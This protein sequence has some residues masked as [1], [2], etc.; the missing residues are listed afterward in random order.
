MLL[1]EVSALLGPIEKREK[2]KKKKTYDGQQI[3]PLVLPVTCNPFHDGPNLPAVAH[4]VG[5]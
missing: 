2:K 5:Q 1:H 3:A 4:P